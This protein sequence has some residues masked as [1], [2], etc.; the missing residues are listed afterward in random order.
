MTKGFILIVA[1]KSIRVLMITT[2]TTT[3]VVAM[4]LTA[5]ISVAAVVSLIIFLTARELVSASDSITA[6][7]VARFFNVG[8]LPLAMTFAVIVVVKIAGMMA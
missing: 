4:G 5:A 8:I 2:V 6:T 7:R 1:G 3:T